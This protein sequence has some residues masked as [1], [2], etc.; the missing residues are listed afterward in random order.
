M[1]CKFICNNYSFFIC[2]IIL[3]FNSSNV[4]KVLE[5]AANQSKYDINSKSIGFV[6]Q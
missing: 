6:L 5:N 4:C 3:I 2:Q 1:Y